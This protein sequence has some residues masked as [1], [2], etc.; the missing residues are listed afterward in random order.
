[1]PLTLTLLTLLVA[2]ADWIAVSRRA[3]DPTSVGARH[4]E[5]VAKPLT[6]VFLIG[7][8]LAIADAHARSGIPGPHRA[9]AYLTIAAVAALV[10]SAIGDVFLMLP[11]DSSAADRNFVI[12]LGAFLLAHV[13]YIAA[14]VRLHA[15]GGYAI[16]FVVTGLVLAGA[17]FATVGLRIRRAAGE[18]DPAL[19]VPVLAYV[20]VISVLVVA[21][22]WTGDLRI[23]PGALLFAVSDTMIGW[24]RFVRKDWEL[25]V[26]IIVTY[27]LAQILLVLGLVRR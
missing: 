15:H 4:A 24:T 25:D 20:S 21:A 10:L 6:M 7:A 9:T 26:P 1:M 16:S 22:W 8:A 18:E 14:F 3:M 13:A 5:Y 23:I 19:A 12:G 2:L 27:H 11:E 17:M